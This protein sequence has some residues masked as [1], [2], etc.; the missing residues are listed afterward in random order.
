M[1]PKQLHFIFHNSFKFQD[2]LLAGDFNADCDYVCKSCWNDISLWT[3]DRFTWLLGNSIDS[4]VSANTD[5]AYDRFQF[6]YFFQ[7]KYS[8]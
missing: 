7:N 8:D 5:C 3:D 2:V 4:T 6:V 1:Q